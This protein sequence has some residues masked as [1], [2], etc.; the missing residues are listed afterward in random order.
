MWLV[1][2]RIISLGSGT[3]WPHLFIS[4]MPFFPGYTCVPP[5]LWVSFPYP[6]AINR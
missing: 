1:S 2:P 4:T 5:S 3:F 6:N